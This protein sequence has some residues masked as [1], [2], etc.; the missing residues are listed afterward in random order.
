M[1]KELKDRLLHWCRW[2]DNLCERG[3]SGHIQ[4]LASAEIGAPLTCRVEPLQPPVNRPEAALAIV[5][6][7]EA[8]PEWGYRITAEAAPFESHRLRLPVVSPQKSDRGE[9]DTTI[10][11]SNS[12]PWFS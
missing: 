4:C 7:S 12:R 1:A 6:P 9:G 8:V 10:V 2:H 11:H 5:V 3:C